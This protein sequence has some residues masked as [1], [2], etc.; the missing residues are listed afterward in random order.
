MRAGLHPDV[1]D[2][3]PDTVRND[4]LGLRRRYDDHDCPDLLR[5]VVQAAVARLPSTQVVS[6]FR[7]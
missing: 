1:L 2:A 4:L 6:L 5:Q 7:G 3:E